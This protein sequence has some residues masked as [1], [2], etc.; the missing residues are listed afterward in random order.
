[1]MPKASLLQVAIRVLIIS[2]YPALLGKTYRYHRG[3]NK[4]AC[5]WLSD[6]GTAYM[7]E[8]DGRLM[9]FFRSDF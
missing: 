7:Q 9:R 2:N 8:D 3:P 6:T 1:M 4:S 5:D